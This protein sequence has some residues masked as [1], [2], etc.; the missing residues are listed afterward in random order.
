MLVMGALW[1][2]LQYQITTVKR[3]SESGD[4][5]L[6]QELLDKFSEW[7]RIREQQHSDGQAEMERMRQGMLS[8]AET[9]NV[10]RRRMIDYLERVNNKMSTMPDRDEIARMFTIAGGR[11]SGDD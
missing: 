3:D 5:K 8:A 7:I 6:R 10:E 9:A 4:A 11:N 1:A 2:L